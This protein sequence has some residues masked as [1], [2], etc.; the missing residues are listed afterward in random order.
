M[1]NNTLLLVSERIQTINMVQE[2]TK[3][4]HY[5][6]TH[7]DK[8]LAKLRLANAQPKIVLID[9]PKIDLTLLE[10]CHHTK[11][12]HPDSVVITLC[13]GYDEKI[14]IASFDAKADDFVIIPFHANALQRRIEY[15]INKT[16][17]RPS[18]LPQTNASSIK[19]D[20]ESYTVQ[21]DN[22]IIP[23]SKKEFEILQLMA[24]NPGKIFKRDELYSAIWKKAFDIKD[25]TIDVH[26]L[27]LR[28]KLGEN[29][30]TTQKGVGYRWM[31]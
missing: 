27:R 15:H 2:F 5:T 4:F 9:L 26:I 21:K 28:K 20:K 8:N 30:I 29:V 25:R 1:N 12:H 24:A 6:F 22:V 17:P 7:T 11:S 13:D 31:V 16:Q 10:F 14:E 3:F 23:V 19:V 18:P